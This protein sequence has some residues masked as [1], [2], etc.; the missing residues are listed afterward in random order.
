MLKS[1]TYWSF[2]IVLNT[3]GYF[4]LDILIREKKNNCFVMAMKVYESFIITSNKYYFFQN[5]LYQV[6]LHAQLL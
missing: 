6:F 5:N 4:L 1:L 3:Y 2:K